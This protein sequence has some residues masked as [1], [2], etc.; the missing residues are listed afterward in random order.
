ML[1]GARFLNDVA[2]VNSFEFADIAEFTE[3]DAASVYFQLIDASLDK[4]SQNFKPSGR[5]YVPASGSTL[6]VI[7]ESIDDSKT[8][9]RYATQPFS[10]DGSIWKLDFLSSDT[11]KGTANLRLKLT[12]SGVLRTGVVKNGLRIY[13]ASC[14]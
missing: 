10:Q 1:L 4:A 7:V 8:I 9:T 14:L 2:N 6:Q 3:G 13:S 5:R 12:E 11:I